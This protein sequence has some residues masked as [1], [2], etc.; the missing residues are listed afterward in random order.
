MFCE[1]R[2]VR[3]PPAELECLG[4]WYQISGR[5]T[6]ELIR[7]DYDNTKRCHDWNVWI[8]KR[9]LKVL[10]RKEIEAEPVPNELRYWNHPME[11]RA[12]RVSVLIQTRVIFKREFRQNVLWFV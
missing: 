1:Y 12:P 5:D 7:S 4:D 11:G 10:I 3:T 2:T 6:K 9:W 8:K